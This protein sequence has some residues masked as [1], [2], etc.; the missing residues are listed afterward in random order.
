MR[1]L[2][3]VFGR[4]RPLN[5]GRRYI[6]RTLLLHSANWIRTKVCLLVAIPLEHKLPNA[7]ILTLNEVFRAMGPP[8]QIYSDEEEPMNSNELFRCLKEMMHIVCKQLL[9]LMLWSVSLE[10]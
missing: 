1:L 4:L 6:V 10:Q 8:K 2:A 3:Q 9:T 7:F 5:D